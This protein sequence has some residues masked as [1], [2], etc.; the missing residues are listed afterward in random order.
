MDLTWRKHEPRPSP[1][2]LVAGNPT[3]Y[4]VYTLSVTSRDDVDVR[5]AISESVAQMCRLASANITASTEIVLFEWDVVYSTLTVV[6]TDRERTLD[7]RDVLKVFVEGR[8]RTWI[9][10]ALMLPEARAT[11]TFLSGHGVAPAF[12][13]A[14]HATTFEPL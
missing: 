8:V 14:H 7:A 9:Q 12:T 4:V 10:E 2:G 13:S 11:L 3:E 5:A 1:F 6:Y